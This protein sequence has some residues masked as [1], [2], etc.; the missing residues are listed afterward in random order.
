MLCADPM[1]MVH[2][3]L[4]SYLEADVLSFSVTVQPQYEPLT[5]TRKLLQ[6]LLQITLVLRSTGMAHKCYQR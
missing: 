4:H 2:S 1:L 3:A 5:L 6:V